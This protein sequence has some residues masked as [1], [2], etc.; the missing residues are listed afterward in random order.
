MKSKL[1]ETDLTQLMPD[2]IAKTLGTCTFRIKGIVPYIGNNF[3]IDGDSA[4]G[5]FKKG[6]EGKKEGKK[7]RTRQYKE[8]EALDQVWFIGKRPKTWRDVMKGTFG[9]PLGA[10]KEGLLRAANIYYDEVM[11][12]N[13]QLFYVETPDDPDNKCIRLYTKKGPVFKEDTVRNAGPGSPP[14]IRCRPYFMDW[15]ADVSVTFNFEK[16]SPREIYL[17]MV[18]FGWW[19]GV[20]GQRPSAPKKSG[21]FGRFIV[22]SAKIALPEGTLKD[23]KTEI[24]NE[25]KKMIKEFQKKEKKDGKKEK[26][27]A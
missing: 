12:R 26:E 14:D 11:T 23:L 27:V 21:Q 24:E 17:W 4:G 10:F 16:V 25:G 22:P 2:I 5:R 8:A 18:H 19:G 20:G 7:I 9:L 1:I 15:W 3:R 13:K 6:M